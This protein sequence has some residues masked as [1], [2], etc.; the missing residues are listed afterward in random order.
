[1]LKDAHEKTKKVIMFDI[2][3]TI[4]YRKLQP[5]YVKKIWCN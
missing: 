5:E 4:V 2:F 1:M 3:D